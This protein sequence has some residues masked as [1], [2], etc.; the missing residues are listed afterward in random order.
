MNADGPMSTFSW[1]CL[2]AFIGLLNL[3][4][5]QVWK[6]GHGRKGVCHGCASC[7]YQNPEKTIVTGQNGNLPL[8]SR[9]TVSCVELGTWLPLQ[10]QGPLTS[11][12]RTQQP[13]SSVCCITSLS[14]Q[15]K[16]LTN[17]GSSSS[18]QSFRNHQKCSDCTL[19][20][21]LNQAASYV[22]QHLI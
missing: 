12:K 9:W 2:M 7:V 18:S 8:G 3:I 13:T 4:L 20:M 22:C 1:P 17:A 5:I 16:L 21:V 6:M 15:L 14:F 19:L 11:G 10:P